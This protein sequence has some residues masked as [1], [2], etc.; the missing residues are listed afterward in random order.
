VSKR[1]YLLLFSIGPVQ[2]FIAAARKTEDLWAGSYLL[3]FL[4]EKAIDK[5]E[6]T[7]SE[8][9]GDLELIYPVK[10]KGADKA[11]GSMVASY[12]NRFLSLVS[13]DSEKLPAICETLADFIYGQFEEMCLFGLEDA[14]RMRGNGDSLMRDLTTHQARELLE[15]FWAVEPIESGDYEG[16]RKNVESRLAAIK[17]NRTFSLQPQDGIVCTVCGERKALHETPYGE[18]DSVGK[19]R[20]ELRRT[21]SKLSGKY[22]SKEER[23]EAFDG[24]AFYT[25]RIRENEALCGVCLGKRTLRDYMSERGKRSIHGFRSTVEISAPLNYYA[26]FTMDGDDMGRWLAGKEGRFSE[27]PGTIGFHRLISEKLA[28]FS[29][30]AVPRRVLEAGGELVY[31]GGDDVLCFVPVPGLFQ[32]INNLRLDFQNSEHGLHPEATASAGVVI[33]HK[34]YPLSSALN[35]ARAMASRAKQYKHPVTGKS[36]DALGVAVFTRSGVINDFVV[37]WMLAGPFV[38]DSLD[39]VPTLMEHLVG[40]M[41]DDLSSSFIEKLGEAFLPLIGSD[42]KR[43]VKIKL[44]ED[45]AESTKALSVEMNRL[46][47]RSLIDR[48]SQFASKLPEYADYLAKVHDVMGS[49]HEFLNW[50]QA[51]RALARLL[52]EN[53]EVQSDEA[54]TNAN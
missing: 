17:N 45:P 50:L 26:I 49:G 46:L 51:L 20:S 22:R 29:G 30:E 6:E 32:L 47:G 28:K 52:K 44:A 13:T 35:H 1:D 16:A 8:N 43:E 4:V 18:N 7:V 34:Q 5:L 19:M 10:L 9:G 2:S 31:A 54:G 38:T 24:T 48:E 3:S 36:K 42:T 23:D 27:D 41:K 33:V 53:K 15:V 37:P 21:W 14:F 11:Y 25:G 12:P 39:N 40:L